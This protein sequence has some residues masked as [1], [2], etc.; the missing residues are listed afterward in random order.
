MQTIMTAEN[1]PVA[2]AIIQFL[3]SNA[4]LSGLVAEIYKARGWIKETGYAQTHYQITPLGAKM[5]QV[6]DG[7]PS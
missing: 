7:Q 5:L 6:D 1:K 3:E 2:P 4:K